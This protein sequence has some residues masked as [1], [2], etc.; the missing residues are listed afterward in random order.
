M[1]TLNLQQDRASVRLSRS[2]CV[3][4]LYLVAV[5]VAFPEHREKRGLRCDRGT[6]QGCPEDHCCVGGLYCRQWKQEGE[7][8]DFFTDCGC[9]PG[10]KCEKANIFWGRCVDDGGSGGEF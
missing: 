5:A 1:G 2:V 4:L 3:A 9:G 8:C 6:N 7:I 10:L